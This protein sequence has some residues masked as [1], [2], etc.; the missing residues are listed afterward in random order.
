VPNPAAVKHIAE[1]NKIP[2]RLEEDDDTTGSADEG[3]SC[4]ENNLFP[5]LTEETGLLE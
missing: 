3:Y 4:F 5:G 1:K 2:P